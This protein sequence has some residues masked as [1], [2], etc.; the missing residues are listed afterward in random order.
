MHSGKIDIRQLFCYGELCA[1]VNYKFVELEF[2]KVHKTLDE[3]SNA[4]KLK[5]INQNLSILIAIVK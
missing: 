1:S 3:T 5:H 2:G 4:D